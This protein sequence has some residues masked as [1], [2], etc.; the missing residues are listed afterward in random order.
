MN[1]STVIYEKF[2][3]ES[4]VPLNVYLDGKRIESDWWDTDIW[5]ERPEEWYA[6]ISPSF[7][8]KRILVVEGDMFR[9]GIIHE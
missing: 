4:R 9:K 8:G 2:G 1:K 6:L 5:I 7:E 3:K